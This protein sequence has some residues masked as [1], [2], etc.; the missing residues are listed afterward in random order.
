MNDAG[1][2]ALRNLVIWELVKGISIGLF[3]F[4]LVLIVIPTFI[5]ARDTSLAL[6]AVVIGVGGILCMV[7]LVFHSITEFRRI[8]R[9]YHILEK[10]E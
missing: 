6:A 9:T 1:V 5:N 3:L 10:Q 8:K 2:K 4:V 7:A